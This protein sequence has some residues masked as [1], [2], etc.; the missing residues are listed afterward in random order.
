MR[1]SYPNFK[2]PRHIVLPEQKR[3]WWEQ[4]YEKKRDLLHQVHWYRIVLDEA[5]AIKNRDSQTSIACRGLMAKYRWAV[6]ATPIL[7][8]VEELY[9]YFKLLRVK[10]TGDFETFK[11]NFCDDDNPDARARLHAFLRQIMMRRTHATT[12]MGRP[13]VTL[14]RNTQNTIPLEFN[15]VERALYDCVERRFIQ[16]IN[17]SGREGTLEKCYSNVLSMLLRL[18][19]MTA[20][21]FMLQ[22]TMMHLFQVEDLE[23]LTRMTVSDDTAQDDPSRNMLAIMKE[24]IRAKTHPED[25]PPDIAP[26]TTSPEEADEE[27]NMQ[28][29]GSNPLVFTFRKY[30]RDMVKGE[31]WADF[32]ARSLCHKCRDV[33]EVPWV[34]DCYHLYCF[35][36][37]NSLQQEAAVR[38]EARAACC[39]CARIFEQTSCC[40]EIE[41]LAAVAS[42]SAPASPA[43]S[44]ASRRNAEKEDLKWISFGGEVLPSTKTAAVRAQIEEWQRDEP[45]KKIIVFSQFHT[46]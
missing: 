11:D 14:P 43:G 18:R 36:C 21:P 2:P 9:A 7:N 31:Q 45:D 19:Q 4:Q 10:H 20:H 12:L 3:A 32:K 27:F 33:P 16:A 41:E 37:L 39:A 44:A 13:L 35:E 6:S 17:Q 26:E 22:D 25:A 46:L 5:Q 42:S 40:S 28:A 15:P 24:R 23:K 38:G 29:E 30:L 8:C 34:T 1:R